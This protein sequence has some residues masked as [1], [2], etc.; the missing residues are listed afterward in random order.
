MELDQRIASQ[1]IDGSS[2]QSSINTR[3][4]SNPQQTETRVDMRT[5]PMNA[6][7]S[8]PF[9]WKGTAVCA[10]IGAGV[11]LVATVIVATTSED[12]LE[13][14]FAA[15]CAGGFSA[16]GAVLGAAGKTAW[17]CLS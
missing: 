3:N 10:A 4:T 5:E 6:P 11:G 13:P 14:S 7:P 16:G 17:H 15:M 1:P 9:P 2:R 8:K 12:K